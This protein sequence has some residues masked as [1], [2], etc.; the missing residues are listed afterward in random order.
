MSARAERRVAVIGA[1][2]AGCEAALAAARLGAAVTVFALSLDAVANMPCNPCIGGTAKGHLVREIDALG[3]EMGKAADA[4]FL[5][6]RMLNTSKGPAVR[7]LRAQTDKRRYMAYMKARL[8]SEP[9]IALIEE[10][11]AGL[12]AAGGRLQAVVTES[13]GRHECDAAVVAAGT[14]LRARCLYGSTVRNT[15]PGGLRASS[16]LSAC[17][18]GLGFALRRFKTG[19]PARIH[20]RGVDFSKMEVQRGDARP[21]PFSFGTDPGGLAAPDAPCYLTYTGRAT[22]DIVLGNIH[23]SAMYSGAIDATG[24]R[25]CP[26]IEDKIVRFP[27]KER[28]QVFVEPEGLS[29]FEMYVQGMSSA[30]PLDIQ[31]KV[32][33]SVAGLE[34]CELL[35]PAYAIEYDVIDATELGPDLQSRRVPGL[36]FAGQICGSSGYEEAAA[37]GLVAGLA[38]AGRPA[39]LGRDEAYIGVLVDDLVTKGTNEPY[40]MMTSRAEFRLLLR[41][42]NADLRLT[43]VGH[44]CGLVSDERYAEF[45]KKRD[46]V[47]E[48]AACLNRIVLAPGA[49]NAAL[50]AR[51]SSPVASGA[52][53]ADL[54]KRP[55]MSLGDFMPAAGALLP[56]FG[57]LKGYVRD[58][59]FEQADI[60]LKYEGYIG[61]QASRAAELAKMEAM[62][63]P[64][65]VPYGEIK[66]LRLEARQKLAKILPKS[67]GQASR[68]PGVS[69]ADIAVLSVYVRA[70]GR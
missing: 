44:R 32:Y 4:T 55:E 62:P 29:T 57:A 64:D 17:L 25:Y 9:N 69:P 51:G 31:R 11:A 33:E 46:A 58:A 2:H 59:V 18:A 13:G 36:Y 24:T 23:K 47:A 54:I 68:I 56:D 66:G 26:S 8:E 39:A 63:L 16:A 67:F 49:A 14:Y 61:L 52:R 65:G 7:S 43:P 42:D 60:L 21:V 6:S 3:G 5:Q 22:R 40:R 50:A 15:G 53:L 28:H 27:D 37:Q 34:G 20:R 10:E 45:A 35:R 19:T 38:A 48:L 41:Q 30:L 12:D 1:G 70:M